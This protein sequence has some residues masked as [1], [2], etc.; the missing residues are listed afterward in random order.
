MSAPEIDPK[1]AMEVARQKEMAIRHSA[2]ANWTLGALLLASII[3]GLATWLSQEPR[4]RDEIHSGAALGLALTTFFL[5]GLLVRMLHPKP[6]TK[7]PQ[8][9]C[10]WNIESD[11]DQ[12]K[13]LAWDHCPGCGLNMSGDI[14]S[15]EKP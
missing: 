11:N 13:W 15:H 8:C 1:L 10:D 3:V 9:G 14:A 2:R 6:C 4:D 7:C 12:Q 5:G